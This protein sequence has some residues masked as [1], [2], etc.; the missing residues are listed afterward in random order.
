VPKQIDPE[1]DPIMA[2]GSV[3]HGQQG[4]EL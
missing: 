2:A 1:V 4:F 3:R